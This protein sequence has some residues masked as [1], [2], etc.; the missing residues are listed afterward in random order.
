[1]VRWFGAAAALAG[2]I[3]GAKDF[4]TE[5]LQVTALIVLPTS[6]NGAPGTTVAPVTLIVLHPLSAVS[7]GSVDLARLV[8]PAGFTERPWRGFD[9]ASG[10]PASSHDPAAKWSTLPTGAPR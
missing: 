3:D 10:A 6:A 2:M 9:K 4:S 1:M 8:L 5:N 7:V